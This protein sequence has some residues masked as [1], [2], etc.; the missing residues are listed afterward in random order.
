MRS[1]GAVRI[2]A[3]GGAV[4]AAGADGTGG[5]WRA[6]RGWF[7]GD[8]R[9]TRGGGELGGAGRVDGSGGRVQTAVGVRGETCFL[10]F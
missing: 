3:G 8:G 2:G 6:L 5:G 1:D 9:G 4:R 10:G 7:D